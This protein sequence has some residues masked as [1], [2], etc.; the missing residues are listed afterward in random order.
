[1]NFNTNIYRQ[2]SADDILKKAAG[3]SEPNISVIA[4]GETPLLLGNQSDVL[5]G[6]D[7]SVNDISKNVVGTS[8]SVIVPNETPLL[9]GKK[10]LKKPS[11]AIS[12]QQEKKIVEN[13]TSKMPTRK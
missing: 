11:S 5:A 2:Q 4:P 1:L 6:A 7:K 3:T 10:A 12:K 9:P 8:T 13:K